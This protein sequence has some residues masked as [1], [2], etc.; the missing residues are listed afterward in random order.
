[1][2]ISLRL[3]M[4]VESQIAGHSARLGL[5]KSALI[6]RSVNEFLA[7]HAQPSSAQIYE[8]AMRAA[9]GKSDGGKDAG[10]EA[11]ELRPHKRKARTALRARLARRSS[12][13][14]QALQAGPRSA[15]KAK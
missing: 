4:D 12:G 9:A 8:Q 2:P 14:A 15:R 11:A 13:A 10:R 3:P 6:V 7:K 1:M 5:T